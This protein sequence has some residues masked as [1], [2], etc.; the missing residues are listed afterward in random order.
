MERFWMYWGLRYWAASIQAIFSSNSEANWLFEVLTSHVGKFLCVE[1]ILYLCSTENSGFKERPPWRPDGK[2]LF[3]GLKYI[4]NLPIR[5]NF[6]LNRSTGAWDF[7]RPPFLVVYM[8]NLHGG[9]MA[10]NFSWPSTISKSCP[11]CKIWWRYDIRFLS[12]GLFCPE[13]FSFPSPFYPS[14]N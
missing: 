13:N 5:W 8:N 10:K 6:G 12:S 4:Q 9:R 2:K 3:S 7:E 14:Y 11:P 1:M